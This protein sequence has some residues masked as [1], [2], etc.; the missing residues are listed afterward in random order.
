MDPAGRDVLQMVMAD[1]RR[2]LGDRPGQVLADAIRVADVEV[3]A[4]RRRIQP[5]GDLQV[6]VGRLQQQPGLGLDQEQHAQVVG[7]LGQRLEDLDEQVD[8]LL[9]RLA[10][11]QRPAR[12]GRDVGRP[13]L[14]A[15]AQGPAGV[16]DPDPAVMR[17]RAR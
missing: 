13:Q 10:R 6:L 2:Q 14:G 1:V 4:D 12:L 15:E 11:G 9:P 5:L 8:R 16:I 3:Q 17:R 7:V